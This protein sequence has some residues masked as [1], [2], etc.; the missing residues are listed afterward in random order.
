[1]TLETLNH[2]QQL[3]FCT[4][5][6]ERSMPNFQLFCELEDRDEDFHKS[7]KILNKVWEYLRGQLTS[8]KNM[9]NQLDTMAELIP[10]PQMFE[11]FGAYPAMDTMVNLQSCLQSV[12]DNSILDAHNIQTMVRSRLTEVLEMQEIEPTKSELWSRQVDFEQAIVEVIC[13]HGS[14][15][16]MVKKLIPLSKDQGVSQLGICLEES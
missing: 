6:C 2:W 4:A 11:H 16:D 7:R 8:L 14:H 13:I 15:A 12:L 1:M 3:A 10:D 5:L 9:E